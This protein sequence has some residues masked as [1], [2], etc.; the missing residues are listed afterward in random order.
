MEV[1]EELAFY[2]IEYILSV[3]VAD[4]QVLH[5]DVEKVRSQCSSRN[6][7]LSAQRSDLLNFWF[8]KNK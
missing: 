6:T 3:S 1:C 5:I 7:W 2:G 8:C 4:S